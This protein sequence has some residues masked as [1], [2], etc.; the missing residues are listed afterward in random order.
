LTK[1]SYLK[2]KQK[3]NL[4]IYVIVYLNLNKINFL[5]LLKVKVVFKSFNPQFGSLS[6]KAIM[7][8][9]L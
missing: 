2:K 6:L 1:A 4:F 5:K 8:A 3:T 9:F 7:N